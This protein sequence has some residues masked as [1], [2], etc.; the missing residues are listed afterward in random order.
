MWYQRIEADGFN[1]VAELMRNASPS[2]RDRAL[3]GAEPVAQIPALV[4]RG[5]QRVQTLYRTMNERLAESEY[6]AGPS[7]SLADIQLLCVIDFGTGWGRMPVP[8]EFTA[9]LAWHQRISTRTSA[10]A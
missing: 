6:V 4:E 3:P 10:K 2:F 9:L 8:A 7:F 1:A 5:R